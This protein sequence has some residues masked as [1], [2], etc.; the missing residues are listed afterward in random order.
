MDPYSSPDIT[1]HHNT[2][3]RFFSIP[4]F[5]NPKP[6]ILFPLTLYP[7]SKGEKNPNA[8]EVS[9]LAWSWP[10]LRVTLRV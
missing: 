3:F 5:L 4:S 1:H 7:D 8:P 6:H 2:N 10:A 9:A